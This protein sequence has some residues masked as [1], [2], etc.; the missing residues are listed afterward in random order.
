MKTSNLRAISL[1]FSFLLMP[2]E[3]Y[4]DHDVDGGVPVDG[5]ITVS[6]STTNSVSQPGALSQGGQTVGVTNSKI[7][8]DKGKGSLVNSQ[9]EV[10]GWPKLEVKYRDEEEEEGAMWLRRDARWRLRL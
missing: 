5:G 6:V 4:G 2:P 8:I 9:E 1:I 7:D 10:G 3:G